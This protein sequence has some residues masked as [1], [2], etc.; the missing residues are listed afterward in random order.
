MSPC[1]NRGGFRNA[2]YIESDLAAVTLLV[3]F[4]LEI[5]LKVDDDPSFCLLKREIRHAFD[6]G[7]I[8]KA[9]HDRRLTTAATAAQRRGS[10]LEKRLR[11]SRRDHFDGS[12]PLLFRST[13]QSCMNLGLRPDGLARSGQIHRGENRMAQGAKPAP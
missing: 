10:T 4:E 3:G 1:G 13:Q 12:L 2:L 7:F 11:Q 9:H 8:F 5:G 6:Q